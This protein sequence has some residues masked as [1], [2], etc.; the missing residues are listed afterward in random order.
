[1]RLAREKS[2][3][4]AVT[5]TL[6]LRPWRFSAKAHRP[7]Q[8]VSSDTSLGPRLRIPGR[9]SHAIV[10]VLLLGLC[11]QGALAALKVEHLQTEYLPN[12][13]GI[14]TTAPRL[15][16]LVNSDERGDV[17]TAYRILVASDPAMLGEAKGDLWDS[18]K[19]VSDETVN[20][21]YAGRA[22]ASGAA[23]FWRVQAWDRDGKA[24]RWSPVGRWTMGIL[25][26]E[27]WKAQWISFRDASPVHA[28]RTNLRLPPARHYRKT[29]AATKPVRRA[30]LHGS[31]LGIAE[32]VVNGQ[33]VGDAY[34]EPGWADYHRRAYYRTH[35]VTDLLRRGDNCLGAVVA[36]GWYSGYV[37]YGLL[38]GY[39]PNKSGRDF[40]GKTPALLGQLE[41]EYVD[42]TRELIGTD[43]SW[44][45][46]GDGP[47]READ[48]I[49]GEAFDARRD[50]ADWCRARGASDWSWEPAIPAGANGTFKAT[51]HDNR[52]PR[53]VELGFQR[54][55]RMQAYAAPPIKVTGELK[56]LEVTEPKP[57]TYIFDLG[58]NIAGVIRLKVKGTAGTRIQLRYGEMLHPDGRLMTENLRRARAT[59]YYTLRGDPKG[60][61]WSPRFTYHGFRYVELTG[62]NSRPGLEAVT[63]LVLHNDT[64]MAGEFACS[65]EVM[66]RFWKNTQWTQR[67]NF[68]EMPTD[69]PQRDERLGW[70][71]DAQAYVRA[72]SYNADV[73]AFFTKWLDDVA[74]AQLENGAYPDYCPYPMGHGAPGQTWGTAWTDAGIIC[75]WTIWKV[76]G[77]TRLLERQWASMTRFMEFR[78]KRAPDFRGRGDG[79]SW[80]DWLNVNEPTPLEYVDTAY[81]KLSADLMGEMAAALGRTGEAAA[82]RELSGRIAL[83][84]GR[85]YLSADGSLKVST[86]T[87]HVLALAVGMLPPN[88]VGPTADRLAARI[89][90]NGN[91]MTTG[92]LGTRDILP[93]LSRNGKHDIAL[94]L[95]Q[96]RQYPSW[97]YEVVN[98]ATTVWERWDSYTKEHGFNGA[99]G[100][101]NASMNS[102][103]HYAF[104]AVTAW[105]FRDLAGIET[106]GPGYRR[107]IIRPGIPSDASPFRQRKDV[108][109]VDWVRARYDSVRG[110]IV[111]A[112]KRT[113]RGLELEVTL[114]ANT[115]ARIEIPAASTECVR[116]SGKPLAKSKGV[117]VASVADG[118]VLIEV[119]SG[120]Y[121]FDVDSTRN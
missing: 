74:E 20:V 104:G 38:V 106:D 68:V 53:E 94:G 92:F 119:G 45:V 88:L 102:F 41:V 96:S 16:W 91:R 59:D 115:T 62:L 97:G 42:G 37:G 70:M 103:S 21:P 98:G 66:T 79:N 95:F 81:F 100:S 6:A 116:E 55:P 67:A 51:F 57:G 50:R 9:L 52:G 30:V 99:E 5:P 46:S 112:W 105:M 8:L 60:E 7:S 29:F 65:D 77:D 89:A 78:R 36:E 118:R 1:M 11:V 110:R 63:G 84:F 101:Q 22:L 49:M 3:H 44:E 71:G 107:V 34:F 58:Q 69:C 82:Y 17:Q 25:R 90:A 14:D 75:P 27:D 35:E 32:W 47:I 80:G 61:A 54:P 43:D 18:G 113:A 109:E 39:G 28:D 19:I 10:S 64:P 15:S 87:A 85:D 108:G 40:Y 121:R 120:S 23:A 73:A 2:H 114:P 13:A 117:R 48:L 26:D 4:R 12:P 86:Q 24:S 56:A 33:R 111:S 83:Q 72:A 93:A 31:A 76:Y